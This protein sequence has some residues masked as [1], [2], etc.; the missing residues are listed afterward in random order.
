MAELLFVWIHSLPVEHSLTEEEHK[1][2]G[3]LDSLQHPVLGEVGGSVVVPC[4]EA[5]PFEL[6]VDGVRLR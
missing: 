6:E 5:H 4:L 2:S 1:S 3:L